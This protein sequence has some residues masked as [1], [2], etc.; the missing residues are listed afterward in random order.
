MDAPDQPPEISFESIIAKKKKEGA[1]HRKKEYKKIMK[2]IKKKIDK[3][4]RRGDTL[5]GNYVAAATTS[6]A[7]L[8]KLEKAGFSIE[9]ILMPLMT[10]EDHYATAPRNISGVS[11]LISW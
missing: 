7:T 4:I 6:L 3:N 11:W 8:L 10:R 5:N 9:P 2:A 1:K